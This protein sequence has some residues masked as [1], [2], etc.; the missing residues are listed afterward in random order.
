MHGK[1]SDLVASV[2]QE[3]NVPYSYV[4]GVP[5]EQLPEVY[6]A[7]KVFVNASQSERM[8]LTI[9]EALCSNCRVLATKLN[10]G[11]SWYPGL[12]TFDPQDRTELQRLLAEACF[13]P[14]WDFT[15]NKAAMTWTWDVVARMLQDAYELALKG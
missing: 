12:K 8:S 13:G 9:A 2:C 4:T 6:M 14:V 10:R 15:P 1:N 5:H 11:N 3:L 7:A